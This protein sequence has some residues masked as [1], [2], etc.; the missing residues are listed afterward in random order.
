MKATLG[1]TPGA[2]RKNRS[3]PGGEDLPNL[4]ELSPSR[5][6]EAVVSEAHEHLPQPLLLGL[7]CG[8][9]AGAFWGGG[10]PG[11]EA[12]G[13]LHAAADD[14]GALRYRLRPG[15]GGA[16]GPGLADGD[17]EDGRPRLARPVPAEPAGQP[18]LLCR[19]VGLG[20]EFGVALASLIIGLLAGNC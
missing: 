17:G 11:A 9:V 3:S 2:W 8:L 16:A 5:P 13:R 20:A 10:A 1:V 12:A 15:L 19:P 18:D 14:G 4:Q 7:L 6:A